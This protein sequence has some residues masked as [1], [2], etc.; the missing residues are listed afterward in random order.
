GRF[1]TTA[2]KNI[3]LQDWSAL[4]EAALA[5]KEVGCWEWMYDSDLFGV[6]NPDT[7]E[8]GYCCVLGNLGEVFALNVYLGA[9]GLDSYWA[10]QDE[11]PDLDPEDLEDIAGMDV[12]DVLAD[13]EMDSP[14][15]PFAAMS[16]LNSQKCL[17][18]SFEDRSDLE[19]EDLNLIR[20]LG[21][22]FRGKQ[23]WPMF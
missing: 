2:E 22:K 1:M 18:A 19:K 20:K 12:M 23:A 7:G 13:R 16:I 21:L 9:E 3:S 6:Q 14:D 17:V 4:Y 15:S 10:L 11:S 8:V 5:F